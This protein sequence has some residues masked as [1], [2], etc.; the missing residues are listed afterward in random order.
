VV[1]ELARWLYDAPTSASKV[2]I[3]TAFRFQLKANYFIAE[4]VN[5]FRCSVYFYFCEEVSC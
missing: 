2:S 4:I 3:Q 1:V 5:S